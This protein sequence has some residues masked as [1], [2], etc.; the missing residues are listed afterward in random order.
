[1][2]TELPAFR[3]LSTAAQTMKTADLGAMLA[4]DARSRDLVFTL[5]DL[6]VDISR[7]RLDGAVINDL[8]KL[9]DET[10]LAA[11]LAALFAG[12]A[13]N[14]SENRPVLHMDQRSNARIDSAEYARLCDF[15]DECRSN[16]DIHDVINI[17]IGGSDLGPAMV[18]MA[19]SGLKNSPN[20]ETSVGPHLHYVSN[21]DP[22]HLHDVLNAC[23]PAHSLVIVTSKTFTTAET[24]RNAGLAQSWL[25]D[26]AA[27]R[28]VGV[29]ANAAEAHD[30]GLSDDCIFDFDQGVGGRYSLWSAVGLP[31]MIDIGPNAFTEFLAGAAAMDAHFQSAPFA[32]NLPVI[33]GLLR[34]WN[35]NFLDLPTLG[36]MPYDQRLARLPAWAQ[37]LEM[38][39]NG[40]SVTRNGAKIDYAT[41]PVIWGEAG[42]GCQH[43]FFQALHQGS[44]LVP[45]DILLPLRP[46]YLTLSG[47]WQASHNVLVANALAQAEAL[48]K[49][50]ENTAEPHRNFAGGRPSSLISWT[51]ST[52]F[53][54]GRLLA[55]YEHITT[56]SGF[57]WDVNSYDQWGVELGKT[58]AKSF[59]AILE[60]GEIPADLSKTAA[61]LLGTVMSQDGDE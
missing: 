35:R 59:E 31:V 3:A 48:A 2:F 52:P 21:V 10:D 13:V 51:R 36:I 44:D 22:S 11:K 47:N 27:G 50:H 24:M 45:L 33:L 41:A 6:R 57:V 34:V 1:M 4:D 8:L 37:Q 42:T 43:S 7:H 23:D 55:L 39:S 18:S 5:D 58:M 17:G 14:L 20:E 40:K 30:W 53:A 16:A 15:A 26:H 28:M 32:Q 25:G 54:I 9:A 46:S 60:S 38:E 49:G 12:E 61:D 29:S 56:V 19:L